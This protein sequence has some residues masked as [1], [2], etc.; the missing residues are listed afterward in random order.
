ML[1]CTINSLRRINQSVKKDLMQLST[2]ASGWLLKVFATIQQYI[3]II[4]IWMVTKVF[5]DH[6]DAETDADHK[7]FR[8][9]INQS[10]IWERGL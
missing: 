3:V 1:E 7:R 8:I 5:R 2:S 6:S 10:Y 4:Y 9:H